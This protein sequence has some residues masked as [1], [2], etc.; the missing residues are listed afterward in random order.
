MGLV[1]GPEWRQTR[2]C[3]AEAFAQRSIAGAIGRVTEITREYMAELEANGRLAQQMLNPGRDLRLLPFWIMADY[4]YGRLSPEQHSQLEALVPL[5]DSLFQRVIQGG[6]TRFSWSQYLP[7]TAN[8]DLNDF[9]A[10]WKQFNDVAYT[11]CKEQ[12]HAPPIVRML[13]AYRDGSITMDNMLQTMDEMLFGNLDVTAGGLT[14][15]PLFM[16]AYPGVQAQL[17]QE[18]RRELGD[19]R[20]AWEAYLLRSD[21]LLAASILEAARLKP[22]AAFSIPQA[23][24][25]DRVVGGYL[26][27][28]RTNYVIDTY[29]LN[30]RNP[31]WG[32][33][34][35]EYRPSRFLERKA[36]DT[37]YHY[38]RF[39][40]GPRQCLGK[41]LADIM[42][43]VIVARLVGGYQLN[44]TPTSSWDKN[45][46]V[47][48]AH[49]DTEILCE[50]IME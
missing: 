2:L 40:F 31:Y 3:I 36:A 1:N 22:I 49:P 19:G 39:G 14:W 16:A 23:A 46:S 17:R 5:R 29:A 48:I 27:P 4:L 32:K 28:G 15:N 41:Y 24:P 47:W 50:K 6:A 25:S 9:K 8:R 38:W 26:V 12:G 35:A 42:I 7:S 13:E 37:R 33:D 21:T 30:V 11:A 18:L 45:P 20:K 10:R 43:R 34:S 44:L